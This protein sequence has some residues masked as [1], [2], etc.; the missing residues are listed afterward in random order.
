MVQCLTDCSDLFITKGSTL[1]NVLGGK[2]EDPVVA[3]KW[4]RW[5]I[6][7]SCPESNALMAG[8]DVRNSV[9]WLH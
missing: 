6:C 7:L 4:K 8:I 9:N 2:N 3:M 5:L 1:H